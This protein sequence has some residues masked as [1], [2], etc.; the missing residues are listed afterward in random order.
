M[1]ALTV[2]DVTG[3]DTLTAAF[4][5]AGAGWYILPVRRGTKRPL[6]ELGDDWQ[7]KSS[8]DPQVI[9]AW[10]AGTGH[11]IALH[12]GRSGAVI[13]DVDNLDALPDC[14]ALVDALEA[15]VRAGHPV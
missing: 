13:L 6:P 7:H 15:H 11:G 12:A 5:Y 10:L 14:P 1:T 8:R 2:P 9:T 4:A 3:M